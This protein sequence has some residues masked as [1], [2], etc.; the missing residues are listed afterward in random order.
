[1][2]EDLIP[3]IFGTAIKYS[4]LVG[5]ISSFITADSPQSYFLASFCGFL[6]V[7][8]EIIQKN[9]KDK[10]LNNLEKKLNK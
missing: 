10:E 8:G 4:A 1:M 7:G 5:G 6:Y 9:K 2:E 3:Y